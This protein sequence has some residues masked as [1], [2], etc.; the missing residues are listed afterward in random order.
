MRPSS[1][2]HCFIAAI[3]GQFYMG[4]NMRLME[5]LTN[6]RLLSEVRVQKPATLLL[7]TAGENNDWEILQCIN[8]RNWNGTGLVKVLSKR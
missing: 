7:S 3:H 2:F 1:Y 8:T 6:V 5:K 4:A